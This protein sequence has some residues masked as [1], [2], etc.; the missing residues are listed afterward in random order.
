MPPA[1]LLS[2]SIHLVVIFGFLIS[3]VSDSA[4]KVANRAFTVLLSKVCS[5]DPTSRRRQPPQQQLI[6]RRIRTMLCL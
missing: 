6:A 2:V 3:P 4:L 5:Q 1:L